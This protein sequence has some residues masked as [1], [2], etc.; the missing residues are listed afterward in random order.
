M[1]KHYK[2]RRL[3][4]KNWGKNTWTTLSKKAMS[5]TISSK[6]V[7]IDITLFYLSD[8]DICGPYFSF[9]SLQCHLC[10]C[11]HLRHKWH[12]QA[13]N[14]KVQAIN[15]DNAYKNSIIVIFLDYLGFKHPYYSKFFLTELSDE[16]QNYV[17]TYLSSGKSCFPYKAVTGFNSLSSIPE[18]WNLWQIEM[19]Y[20]R[21]HDEGISQ[22]QWEGC[23]KLCKLLKMRNLSD[24]NNIY[25]IQD[26]YI[27]GVILE[28][29]W[30]KNKGK[31]RFWS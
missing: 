12:W 25:N 6:W 19:F 11:L 26:I 4:P 10:P 30:Q 7:L 16:D 17:L 5:F 1:R 29:R 18:N 14:K 22:K 28:Y 23:G 15:I 31:Y 13:I 20:S 21:L 3:L 24:F 27:M 2:M 9:M 8:I